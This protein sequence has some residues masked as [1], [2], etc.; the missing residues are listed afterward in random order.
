MKAIIILFFLIKTTNIYAF[1]WNF[2]LMN[3]SIPIINMGSYRI[4]KDGTIPKTCLDY[5]NP[6]VKYS[7]MG[8]IGDGVYRIKPDGVNTL[9]VY[10]DMAN[11]GWTAI[12]AGGATCGGNFSGRGSGS[13]INPQ[14]TSSYTSTCGYIND[15]I[16]R[17]IA[18]VSTSVR[19]RSGASPSSYSEAISSGSNTLA[20]LR[21]GGNW[22]NGAQSE[23]NNWSW[24]WFC[25]SSASSWPNMF[26]ACGNG[27]GVHWLAAPYYQSDVGSGARSYSSAWLK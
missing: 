1:A 19:L 9:D 5:R 2:R 14:N 10:C 18:T 8:D 13:I 23:F 25:G 4:F 11:G 21:S 24:S 17:S 15:G 6:P 26:H 22:H 12:S 20:A 16:M 27:G 7:Y 3:L